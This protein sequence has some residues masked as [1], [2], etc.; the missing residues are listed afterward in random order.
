MPE[1]LI[2]ALLSVIDLVAELTAEIREM[3][4][5]SSAPAF[6]GLMRA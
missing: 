2:P 3:E 1:A 4:R 5:S 6:S